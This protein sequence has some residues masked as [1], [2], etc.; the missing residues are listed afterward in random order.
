MINSIDHDP[1]AHTLRIE[2]ELC[3]YMQKWYRDSEP[4]MVR[5]SLLFSAVASV[6]AEPDLAGLAWSEQFDGQILRVTSVDGSPAEMETLKFAIETS[7]YRTKEEGML[8]LEVSAGECI[9]RGEQGA[10]LLESSS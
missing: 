8:I 10:G 3:N 5:G 6:R 7:D 1:V 9:W 4:E 2:I